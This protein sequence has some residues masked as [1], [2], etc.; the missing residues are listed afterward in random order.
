VTGVKSNLKFLLRA[1][2]NRSV[3]RLDYKGRI[4]CLWGLKCGELEFEWELS[5]VKACV[6]GNA[7][8]ERILVGLVKIFLVKSFPVDLKGTNSSVFNLEGLADGSRVRH[9]SGDRKHRVN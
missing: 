3:G 7:N 6:F 1:R 2:T 5:L 4:L 8:G 9:N